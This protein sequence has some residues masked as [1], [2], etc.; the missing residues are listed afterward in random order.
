MQCVAS[1]LQYVAIYC[2]V[3]QVSLRVWRVQSLGFSAFGVGLG[4]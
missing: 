2:S 4:V 3:L 1:V